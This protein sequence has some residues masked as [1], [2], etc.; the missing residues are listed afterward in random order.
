MAKLVDSKLHPGY[1]AVEVQKGDTLS[2]IAVDYGNGLTYKQ[3]AGINDIPNPDLIYIGQVIELRSATTGDNTKNSTLK[4]TILQFGIQSNTEDTLFA[5]WS[6]NK[7]NTENYKVQWTYDTGD[8]VWFIGSDSTTEH[9]QSTYSIPSNAKCVRFRVKP[10]SKTKTSNE[11][12]TS[13]WTASWS[14]YKTHNVSDN[15]PKT[16]DVPEV[17]I[18]Q[19]TLTLTAELDNLDVNA[20]KIQFQVV[21][22]NKAVFKTGNVSIVTGHAS[23]SCKVTSGGEY[24][25]RCR[26]IKDKQYS[27]W[28]EYSNNVGT[29]PA[30]PSGITTIRAN[31]KTEVYLAWGV[32]KTAT[33][34]EI[35]YAT[36][37]EHFDGSNQTTTQSNIRDTHYLLGGLETGNE[38]FFRVRAVNEHGESP[39]TGIKSTVIGKKPAA[40]TT[41]S[42]STTVMVGEQLVLYWVHNSEDGSSQVS[43][44][45]EYRIGSSGGYT[46]KT[47]ANSTDEDEKDK[48]SF[49]K[50]ETSTYSEGTE[51]Q[52]RVRTCG[53]T[54]E[55]GEWSIQRSVKIYAAPTLELSLLTKDDGNGEPIDTVTTFPIFVSAIAGP[56]TQQPIGYYLSVISDEVYD[57]VDA[58]GNPK[59]VNKGE[60]VYSKYFDIKT[61]LMVELSADSIDLENNMDYTVKCRVSMNSGLT[62]EETAPMHVSWSDE[63]YEPNAEIS[64]D[65][66]TL[67]AYIRPYCMSENTT[68]YRVIKSGYIY[69]ATTEKVD[70]LWGEMVTGAKTS[71]GKQVY[72][73]ILSNGTE[74]YYHV[75]RT[76][77]LVDGITLSVYRRE[78]D[79]TFVEIATGLNNSKNTCVTDPHPALDFARYRIVAK[80][81]ATGAVGYAD[82]RGYS[83]GEKAVIIQWNEEWTNFDSSS[84]D[85]LVQPPWSGSLLRLPYNIDV[86]DS[87]RPDV[88]L[89]EY[90][91]RAH[92]T[93]YYGTQTGESAV[94][95]IDIPKNDKDTL[96]AL[97]RL[98]IWMGDVYVREP[99]GSGYWANITVSFSQKHCETVIP[100]T[101]D[102]TRVEGGM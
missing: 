74:L 76:G 59:T 82:I 30:A 9:M 56:N 69:A 33:S 57:T 81:D 100:V 89:V 5:T 29:K 27:E 83:V 77:S 73:G 47:I 49:Y 98:A 86:S 70:I 84:E 95:N 1:K 68:Y 75:T 66:E 10:I 8:E 42:S 39:W 63:G 15:P 51:I 80:S 43:A 93:S 4:A 53:V 78:F 79:G 62:V 67:V 65:E 16:P 34:Y 28:S 101:L 45:L 52:W 60:E 50:F 64:V 44:Q 3:L 18:D 20:T 38:Y 58:L 11:K 102:I 7:E 90:I 25:V 23:F 35:E 32:S 46:Q 31:S 61:N 13:Y 22:D 55:Y 48:T 96:Y 71:S 21:K 24:K 40:P 6:W 72:S 17:K 12:E 14:S 41:W 94:W 91:G 85:A 87:R 92:P 54:G 2:Q 88:A 37:K 19:K 26:S 36:K 99:S 97:R